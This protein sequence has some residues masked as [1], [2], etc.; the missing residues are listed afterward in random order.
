VVA[1][2]SRGIKP[3]TDPTPRS[4][5]IDARAHAAQVRLVAQEDVYRRVEPPWNVLARQP[6]R[7]VEDLVVA[8]KSVSCGTGVAPR[9]RAPE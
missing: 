6:D 1:T 2:H 4:A 8:H 9:S 7:G 3:G 5:R